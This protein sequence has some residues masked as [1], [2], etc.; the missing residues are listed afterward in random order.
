MLYERAVAY[1]NVDI[2][3]EGTNIF[4]HCT[5]IIAQGRDIQRHILL[6]GRFDH[7]TNYVTPLTPPKAH[8]CC[9]KNIKHYEFF[10]TRTKDKHRATGR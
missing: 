1:L 9:W 8:L 2:A 7:L 6:G 10:S 4:I 5:A 3:V